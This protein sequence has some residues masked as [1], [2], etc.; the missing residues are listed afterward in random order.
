MSTL[1]GSAQPQNTIRARIGRP[2]DIE[3]FV[4]I[5]IDVPT[6]AIRAHYNR[7]RINGGSG[8]MGGVWFRRP[9]VTSGSSYLFGIAGT[10]RDQYG[11]P[12]ANAAVKLFRTSDDSLVHST[13]SGPDGAYLVQTP[14]Y[15]EA[16]Y[17]ITYKTG[18]PD[19]F[20]TSVNTLLPQ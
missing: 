7:S 2:T 6:L 13:T 9:V 11:T 1:I 3:S 5:A 18:T 20:G 15:G 14:H 8:I 17:L 4:R 19:I 12:V 16:H 10:V